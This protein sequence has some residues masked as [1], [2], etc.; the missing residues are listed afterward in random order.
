MPEVSVLLPVYNTKEEYLRAA[1][2]GILVQSFKDF[3]LIILNDAS[4]DENVERVIL[5]YRDE[6]IVYVREKKNLGIS[7]ARNKLIGLAKGGLLAVLDHD[8]V[9]AYD[10][11]EKQVSFMREN[12]HVGIAGSAYYLMPR[13]RLVRMP[14]TNREIE[15][16]MMFSCP[17]LH[18]SA[19]IRKS[20]L[21]RTGVRYE[22]ENFP[23]E[24]YALFCRL[25]GKTEFANLDKPLMLYR[26]HKAN[27]SK[28][29][30]KEM[31]AATARLH[32]EIRRNHP[33]IFERTEK[34]ITVERKY[35]LSGVVFLTVS[36]NRKTGRT[37]IRPFNLFCLFR[38]EK[39]E[40]GRTLRLFGRL[41][42][43]KE[44]IKIR[45]S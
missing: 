15:N 37:D 8:D 14:E 26:N 10:R 20:V 32:A 21:E 45:L 28:T 44:R 7:G 19:M 31:A 41:P 4:A 39:S 13:G 42:V 38:L 24:D 17:I 9:P 6:R 2:D 11:L 40:T 25:I 3:E 43:F 29:A 34:L 5:S 30:K 33:D 1:V 16:A 35:R 12:P 18:P 27:T 36:E 22:Q 23:A